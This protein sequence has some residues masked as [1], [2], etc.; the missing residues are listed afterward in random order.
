[1]PDPR[2]GRSMGLHYGEEAHRVAL[3]I[4]S[5]EASL[6]E[7]AFMDP[8]ALKACFDK[9]HA[10]EHL[11]THEA[12]LIAETHSI[13]AFLHALRY[14]NDM[15][16]PDPQGV[17][18][19]WSTTVYRL[20]DYY[21]MMSFLELTGVLNSASLESNKLVLGLGS[22]LADV[23]PLA[24]QFD[25]TDIERFHPGEGGITNAHEARLLYDRLEAEEVIRMRRRGGTIVGVE[26]DEFMLSV[27]AQLL[28]L[29]DLSEIRVIND[30]ARAYLHN[31]LKALRKADI[32]L[33]VI[34]RLDPLMAVGNATTRQEWQERA[35]KFSS[36]LSDVASA[37]KLQQMN[38]SPR[39]QVFISIGSGKGS[40]E[41]YHNYEEYKE[42]MRVLS[43]MKSSL[44]KNGPLFY[45]DMTQVPVC[46]PWLRPDMSDLVILVA[47]S[48]R[49]Q[50]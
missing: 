49:K 10:H 40:D 46:Q 23:Y 24:Y 6:I 35:T 12:S 31:N 13:V 19:N 22:A 21:R 50:I 7:R 20:K 25:V 44:T 29:T 3:G 42:R 17:P 36:T 45:H 5:H 39:G 27:G 33:T 16:M 8:Q 15:T 26:N 41:D 32:G 30:N 43:A 37:A 9:Y 2:P 14:T 11:T 18:R 47:N 48:G 28:S 34:A 1:M 4:A 38:C